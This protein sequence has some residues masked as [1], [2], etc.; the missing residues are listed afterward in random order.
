[1]RLR[2]DVLGV[3]TAVAVAVCG[4]GVWTLHRTDPAHPAAR[5]VAAGVANLP[6]GAS[7]PRS[8]DSTV[9]ALPGNEA[10]ALASDSAA[11]AEPGSGDPTVGP[12]F[13]GGLDAPHSCTA[14]VVDSP[15]GDLILTAAHC[16]SGTGV[17][18]Q[19]AP[20]YDDGYLPYGVWTVV[21]A[22]VDPSWVAT[23]DPAH[24]Y[25]FLQLA[26]QQHDGRQVSVED[27]TGGNLL[28]ETPPPG[29]SIRAV[30][31]N[32]G[33][34]DAPISC[35]IPTFR[36]VTGFGG[37]SCDGYVSG[38]SGSPFLQRLPGAARTLV[39]GVIGGL[40]QGGC[41]EYTSYAAPFGQDTFRLWQ[42][43]VAGS[44][45]DTVPAPAGDGC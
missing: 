3:A 19:F 24:D 35:T 2:G 20:G 9:A 14:S 36:T 38:S 40:H 33:I 45:P 11:A 41:D 7:A 32:S 1:V 15:S 5:A 30:G 8:A 21:A 42:R 23:Q 25:A 16:L 26:A 12:L 39:V 13:S 43:A 29:T 34:D 4:F 17:G 6:A 22:Y 44:Q 31:Y 10:Q 37:F 27:E 18:L 28:A